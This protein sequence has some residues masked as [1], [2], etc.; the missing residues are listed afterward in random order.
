M[1]YGLCQH[2]P[3]RECALA[4]AK[5]LRGEVM[6]PENDSIYSFNEEM[7]VEYN[8]SANIASNSNNEC[9]TNSG[10]NGFTV[11][12]ANDGSKKIHENIKINGCSAYQHLNSEFVDSGIKLSLGHRRL[13]CLARVVLKRSICLV[14]D[15]ATS[16]LDGIAETSNANCKKILMEKIANIQRE[17]GESECQFKNKKKRDRFSNFVLNA[18]YNKE[19][20]EHENIHKRSETNSAT[21]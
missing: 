18:I 8:A 19:K 16:V 20:Q 7:I 9:L 21:A 11:E 1:T 5:I 6:V 2:W 10:F 15:K 14:L 4:V 13:L 17:G 12:R 3:L